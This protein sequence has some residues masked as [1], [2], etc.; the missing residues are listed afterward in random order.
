MRGCSEEPSSGRLC[1]WRSVY[2]WGEQVLLTD[3]RGWQWCFVTYMSVLHRA[4][5][6]PPLAFL[7]WFP[8]VFHRLSPAPLPRP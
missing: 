4:P 8:I 1:V 7:L 2:S 6:F 3:R 5:C